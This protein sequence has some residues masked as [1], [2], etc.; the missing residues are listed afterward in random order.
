M[1][2]AMIALVAVLFAVIP[3][4]FAALAIL[5]AVFSGA[6]VLLAAGVY[7]GKGILIG[8]VLGFAA[9]RAL[10]KARTAERAD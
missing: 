7:A 5:G 1:L 6:A 3:L 4:V 10:R 2:G 8:I 9:Y